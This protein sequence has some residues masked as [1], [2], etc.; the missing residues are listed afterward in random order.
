MLFKPSIN[1]FS[2]NATFIHNKFAL[3]K[4]AWS[5][6]EIGKIAFPKIWFENTNVG[7]SGKFAEKDGW[8][9]DYKRKWQLVFELH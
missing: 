8:E 7:K 3:L 6:F 9:V 1:L 5:L 2:A 4:D